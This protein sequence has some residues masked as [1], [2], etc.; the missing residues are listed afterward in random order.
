MSFGSYVASS[1]TFTSMKFLFLRLSFLGDVAA[2]PHTVPRLA[3]PKAI[4]SSVDNATHCVALSSRVIAQA[5]ACTCQHFPSLK[6]PSAVS[7]ST[8]SKSRSGVITGA[9]PDACVS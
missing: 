1:V 2:A 7:I 9:K 4:V 5:V 8:Y 6:T 3:G